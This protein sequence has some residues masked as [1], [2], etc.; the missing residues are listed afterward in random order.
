MKVSTLEVPAELVGLLNTAAGTFLS[1]RIISLPGGSGADMNDRGPKRVTNPEQSQG[2][3]FHIY[4]LKI[5]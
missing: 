2:E 3:G 4:C 1:A 5:C